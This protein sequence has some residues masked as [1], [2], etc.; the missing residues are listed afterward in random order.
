MPVSVV[1]GDVVELE[2]Q[3]I[4]GGFRVEAREGHG[5]RRRR[6]HLLEIEADVEIG[7]AVERA[8]RKSLGRL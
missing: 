8:N 3:L 7:A 6:R 4:V 1:G 2:P 5:A